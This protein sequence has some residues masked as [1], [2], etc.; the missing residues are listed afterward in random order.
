M[1]KGVLAILLILVIVIIFSPALVG[2]LAEQQVDENLNWAAQKSGE[3]KVTSQG[4]DRGWFSSEG[5]HRIELGDGGLRAALSAGNGADDMPA[6]VVNTRL[7]H[8]LI[9]VTSM[10]REKGSLAPGLGSAVST[11][12]LQSGDE[13]IDIPGVIYSKISLGGDLESRYQVDAGSKTTDDGVITWS[14]THL[15]FAAGANGGDIQFDGNIG[16]ISV[17][18]GDQQIS[19]EGMTLSGDQRQTKYG[20]TVGDINVEMGEIAVRQGGTTTTGLKSFKMVADSAVDNEEASSS[21]TMSLASQ[22][23]K[24]FGAVSMDV[25]MR[26]HGADATALGKLEQRASQMTGS[27]D[28][29]AVFADAEPE[30][31]ALFSK[32]VKLDIS[33]FDINL[34]MGKVEAVMNLDIL[35]DGSNGF[36]WTSLLTGSSANLDLKVPASVVEFATQINP[37]AGMLVGMGFLKKNGDVY[38][39]EAVYEKTSLTVNGA[40]IPVPLGAFQ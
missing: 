1:K 4:F 12:Q 16:A 2:K 13:S 18:G 40:P 10:S 9:P 27:D 19:I 3:L 38:E 30:F 34:P 17:D 29:L 7:D 26:M 31:A 39:M 20:F 25:D 36:R 35:G 6:L 11:L 32:G 5:Q 24:G 28:P 8:G 22:E 21:V 37:Q 15:D 33:K 14:D 23:I